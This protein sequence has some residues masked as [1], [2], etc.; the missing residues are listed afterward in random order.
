MNHD[1]DRTL[2]HDYLCIRLINY[3]M[4]INYLDND[5]WHAGKISI[6]DNTSGTYLSFIGHLDKRV[7]LDSRIKPGDCR[8][9]AAL[10][11]MASKLSYENHA[12][13]KT[14]V[15]DHWKVSNKLLSTSTASNYS[16][17]N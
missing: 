10:S 2:M 9:N 8:Y 7:R 17:R 14:T 1:A 3:T 15:E 6:P 13:I 16:I 11:M 5:Y 12:C 4:E